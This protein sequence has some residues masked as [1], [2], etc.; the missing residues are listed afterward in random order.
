MK[1]YL[2]DK[3]I[4]TS[5]SVAGF[6]NAGMIWQER[7]LKSILENPSYTGNLYF[8]REETLDFI[9]KKEG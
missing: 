6:K 3:G 5:R 2:T 9:T 7:S 8:H 1:S 4:H